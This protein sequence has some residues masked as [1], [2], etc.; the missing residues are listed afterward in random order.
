V[1]APKDTKKVLSALRLGWYLAEVR[2][3]NWPGGPPGASARMPDRADHAL[4][5]RAERSK[6]ELRIEAQAVVARL[7]KNHELEDSADGISYC[8]TID[9]QAGLLASLRA[10]K[11]SDALQRALDMLRPAV[12][13]RAVAGRAVA[14]R[15]DP[16]EPAPA[17]VAQVVQLLQEVLADRESVLVSQAGAVADAERAL[18]AADLQSAASQQPAEVQAEAAA[19][20]AAATAAVQLERAA[21]MGEQTGVR[22]LRQAVTELQQTIAV[23]DATDPTAERTG[24]VRI[25]ESQR[26]IADDPSVHLPWEALAELIWRFDAHIQ[27]RLA[28]ASETQACGYQLGRGLAETYWSL[29][30]GRDDGSEGW[31]FLLGE[32]RC[33]ELSRMAGRLAA[34]MGEYTAPAIVGSVEVWKDVAATPDWRGDVLATGQALYLQIRRWYELIILGQDP[35]TLIK[36][37]GIIRNYRTLG[38]AVRFFWPQLVATTFGLGFL[39]T[40]LVSLSVGAGSSW[41]RTLSGLLAATGLSLAGI[42]GALKNSA[43]AMLKRLRQ[44]AYTDLVADAVLTAPPPPRKSMTQQAIG[45]RDLTPAT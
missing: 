14:G 30:P 10:P 39:A 42:T 35:T 44:D 45:R 43:Q 36:P 31:A 17:T 8:A 6:T 5:L 38:R 18:A 7:A 32:E 1:A 24:L 16:G 2:G 41:E 33:N 37:L 28:A 9:H 19:Q 26:V 4:P 12:A 27:D 22:A 11:A 15:A 20:L 40:L 21:T 3:R 29:D 23:P 25:Q 13:G 34:Y